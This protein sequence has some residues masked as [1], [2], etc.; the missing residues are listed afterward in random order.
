MPKS[1]SLISFL[2]YTIN[3]VHPFLMSLLLLEAAECKLFTYIIIMI[4]V[5]LI[6][7]YLH[8]HLDCEVNCTYVQILYIYIVYLIYFNVLF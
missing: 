1:K 8:F 7:L 5:H 3:I 6:F 4:F 2:Y